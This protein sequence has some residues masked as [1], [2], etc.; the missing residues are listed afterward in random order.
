MQT[1]LV[2]LQ[3]VIFKKSEKLAKLAK[4]DAEN[5]LNNLI[6]FNEI[7]REKIT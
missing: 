7:F 5:L 4:I 1:P 6:N 2:F 3:Q